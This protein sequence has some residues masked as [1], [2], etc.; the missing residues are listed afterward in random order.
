M[1]QNNQA[2]AELIE[3]LTELRVRNEVLEKE[4]SQLRKEVSNRRTISDYA[5]DC[6]SWT[7]TNGEYIYISP[8]CK[9]ITGY[10]Q[11]EFFKNPKLMIQITHPDD[12]ELIQKHFEVH[13]TEDSSFAIEYRVIT[14]AGK[15][16]W[17]NHLCQPIYDDDGVWLGRRA[18]SRDIT[19]QKQAEKALQESEE[20]YRQLVEWSP[21]AILVHVE[22]KI[23]FVNPATMALFG[24]NRPEDLI[25]KPV[26]EFVHPDYR[27]LVI[28]RIRTVQKERKAVELIHEKLI[29]LNGEII[30]TEIAV[31]Y[32]IYE[33][34]TANL[35][36]IRDITKRTQ[37]EADLK[38]KDNAIASS[39]SGIAIAD[40]VGNLIYVNRVFL[41]MWGYDH[42]SEVIGK[43]F[44]GLWQVGEN[45]V[46]V[47]ESLMDQD[48][49]IGEL[50]AQKKDGSIF[51]V[52]LVTH[53]I[54]DEEQNPT[55]MMGSFIDITK[56]KK[57]EEALRQ[58]NHT[59]DKFFSIIAHDLKNP[60]STIMFMTSALCKY[61]DRLK[62]EKVKERV[63]NLNDS[64][65]HL[66]NL[67]ENLLDWS[68]TQL[69]SL[70]YEPEKLK[71]KNI[72]IEA[73]DLLRPS[74][75]EK[76]ITI[77][78]HINETTFVYADGNM[79]T[80]VIR[81]LLSNAIKFTSVGQI[82]IT[83]IEKI[84]QIEISVK[85]MGI[86]IS[87]NDQQKLF[88]ID[89]HH[90]TIGTAEE[91]GTGLGLILCKEFVE[92]QGGRIWVKSKINKGSTFTFTL[93]K[94]D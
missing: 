25:G 14:R 60:I 21:D 93:P 85:D 67:L 26:L 11:E 68:R 63:E 70:E 46:E 34:H 8:S 94:A 22:G 13:L 16:R 58:A 65:T 77:D 29:D 73:V 32:I 36:V 37:I 23:V 86:G 56:R 9:R 83:A 20:R 17:I 75:K 90:T 66:Y 28:E 59:K 30:D 7:G 45:A 38:V 18:S 81:N 40:L 91:K 92:K 33:G 24:A 53:T 64:I 50:T 87:E 69:G 89:V 55:Y 79:V 42:K 39:I 12:R 44:L 5:Y 15:V 6:E 35:V 71:L 41:K 4:V 62:R 78:V 2:Q 47:V 10:T 52:E 74:A 84:N 27:E 48:S 61:Y 51:Y 1:T 49:W 54:W 19:E 3:E 82:F 88:R 57:A 72:V 43:P 80:T 76:T 31:T